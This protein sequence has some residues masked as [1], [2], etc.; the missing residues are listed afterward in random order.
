MGRDNVNMVTSRISVLLSVG[1]LACSRTSTSAPPVATGKHF[2]DLMAEVGRRFERAGRAVAAGRWE[3]A[4]YDLGEIDEVFT[5]DVPSAI[6]PDDVHIDL[7]PIA[8]AF[9][10]KVPADLRKPIAAHDRAG[11]EAAFARAAATCNGC[12]QAAGRSFIEVPSTIEAA[13]PRLD[14]VSAA[15]PTAPR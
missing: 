5:L 13:V 8:A 6:M 10:S 2:G 11:F 4:D 12:H 3:L 1:V 9:A 14:P 7:R 15:P